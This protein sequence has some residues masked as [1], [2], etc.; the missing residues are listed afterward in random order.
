MAARKPLRAPRMTSE[1]FRC[2][3][4]LEGATLVLEGLYRGPWHS[5]LPLALYWAVGNVDPPPYEPR[6]GPIHP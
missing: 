3:F 5:S 2:G 4:W 1:R 6:T